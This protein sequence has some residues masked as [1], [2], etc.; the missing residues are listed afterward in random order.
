MEKIWRSGAMTI[1][2]PGLLKDSVLWWG[3]GLSGDL[4]VWGWI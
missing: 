4:M 1:V 2:S 3:K